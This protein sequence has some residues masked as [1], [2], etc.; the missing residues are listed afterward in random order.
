[1][2]GI[3]IGLLWMYCSTLLTYDLARGDGSL[4]LADRAAGIMTVLVTTV[5]PAMPVQ[6][7]FP[8]HTI[9]A[10]AAVGWIPLALA[11]SLASPAIEGIPSAHRI[12]FAMIEGCVD[13]M[14][15]IFGAWTVS[16]IRQRHMP[17]LMTDT[18]ADL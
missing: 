12:E 10:A 5:A 13:W 15:V 9:V 14:A 7:L 4:T 3:A 2:V 11:L 18:D 16:R 17:E 1:M 8:K 6:S